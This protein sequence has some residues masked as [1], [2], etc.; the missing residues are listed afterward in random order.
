MMIEYDPEADAIY[1]DLQRAA[2]KEK[3]VARSEPL[4]D[5]RRVAYAKNGDPIGVEFLGVSRGI[6][7]DGVP[8]ADCVA[9]LLR[10]VQ[11]LR[12]VSSAR[13]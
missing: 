2:E 10:C 11:G 9:E 6:S 5:G 8:E 12:V 4:G 3:R 13:D 7:L 1:V